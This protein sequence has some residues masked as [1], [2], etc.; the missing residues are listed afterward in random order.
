MEL[1][2]KSLFVEADSEHHNEVLL[3]YIMLC[4]SRCSSE[5]FI[6]LYKVFL[7]YFINM[8]KVKDLL[9]LKIDIPSNLFNSVVPSLIALSEFSNEKISFLD[10][11]FTLISKSKHFSNMSTTNLSMIEFLVN[12]SLDILY[13]IYE[14]PVICKICINNLSHIARSSQVCKQMV[15]KKSFTKLKDASS[16]G[17][18][19]G[20][21]LKIARI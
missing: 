8:A 2:L 3:K 11:Y 21:V 1:C 19:K 9:H 5:S 17:Q 16:E 18:S 13:E 6:R 15:L 20:K 7:F 14:Y 10:S 12:L 4:S